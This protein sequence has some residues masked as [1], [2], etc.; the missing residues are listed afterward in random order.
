MS[1]AANALKDGGTLVVFCPSIT[2]IASCVHAIREH[3][4]P[5]TYSTVLEL[6]TGMSSGRQWDVRAAKVRK[7]SEATSADTSNRGANR[8]NNADA[9]GEQPSTFTQRLRTKLANWLLRG[10]Q[11]H[12]AAPTSTA[13]KASTT[14]VTER[15]EMVARPTVGHRVA[16]GGFLGVWH[17]KRVSAS[18]FEPETSQDADADASASAKEPEKGTGP[19]VRSRSEPKPRLDG[20]RER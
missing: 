9:V 11:S 20:E 8:S 4:L 10:V 3:N 15:W 5:I 16:G 12:A 18:A 14:E 13:P 19:T 7:P 1:A 6:G 17:K 2:Q